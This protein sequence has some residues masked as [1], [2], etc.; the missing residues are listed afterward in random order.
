MLSYIKKIFKRS[1]PE[2]VRETIED[3]IEEIDDLIEETEE[4]DTS[5]QADERKLLVNV[6]DLKDLQAEDLMTP[7]AEM[8]AAP[9]TINADDLIGLM[10]EHGFS[11]I[12]IYHDDLDN[13]IG[14]VYI[15]DILH[16]IHSKKPINIHHLLKRNVLCISPSMQALDLLL[17]M[18]KTGEHLAIV[19]DEHGG[20]DGMVC[21]SDII[22]EIVGDIQ[23]HAQRVMIQIKDDGRV[24]V[25][26]RVSIE[27][28]E[29]ELFCDL[30]FTPQD[31]E[32]IETLGGLLVLLVNRVP[33]RGD[34]IKHPKGLEFEILDADPRRI[35]KV[36]ILNYNKRQD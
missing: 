11:S 6:L 30:S 10:T 1:E 20:T 35:K 4:Q 24:L 36:Q 31:D 3:L 21:F 26:A 28:L 27:E 34:I 33:A 2:T 18:R 22:E 25:D 8:I 12:P 17:M 9:D 14:Y 23:D 32:D 13:I 15:K 5:L 7:R 19:A 29:E 16:F